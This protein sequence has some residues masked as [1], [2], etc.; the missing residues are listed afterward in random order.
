MTTCWKL[1]YKKKITQEM[2]EAVKGKGA[3]KKK[4]IKAAIIDIMSQGDTL[5]T[6]E[7]HDALQGY[8]IHQIPVESSV[9]TLLRSLTQVESLGRIRVPSKEEGRTTKPIQTWSLKSL[10]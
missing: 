8:M 2:I 10:E 4:R 9:G 1:Q 6:E 3:N 5:T 7:V